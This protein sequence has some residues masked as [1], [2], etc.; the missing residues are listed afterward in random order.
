MLLSFK[1]MDFAFYKKYK[2]TVIP[3]GKV[4]GFNP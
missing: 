1:P 4:P 2:L 3:V